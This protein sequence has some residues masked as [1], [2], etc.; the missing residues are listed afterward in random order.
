MEDAAAIV[1]QTAVDPSHCIRV[2]FLTTKQV[3]RNW[4]CQ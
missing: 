1:E 2:Q 4:A 3:K